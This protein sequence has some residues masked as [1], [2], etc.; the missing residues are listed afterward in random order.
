MMEI[1]KVIGNEKTGLKMIH[2]PKNSDIKVGDYVKIVKL[3]DEEEEVKKRSDDTIE[4]E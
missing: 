3:K 4:S 2:I 1:K